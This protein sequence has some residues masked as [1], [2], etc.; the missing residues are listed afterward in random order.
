MVIILSKMRGTQG[1]LISSICHKVTGTKYLHI[2]HPV[3]MHSNEG[4]GRYPL[5]IYH[6]TLIEQ[7]VNLD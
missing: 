3:H 6:D 7:S 2:C 4:M 5:V 1:L